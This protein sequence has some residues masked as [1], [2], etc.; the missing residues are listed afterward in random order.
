MND[1]FAAACVIAIVY[2][3]I[4]LIEIRFVSKEAKS[5]R[6]I[7]RDTI[8]VYI[9]SFLAMFIIEHVET[10]DLGKTNAVAFVGAPEF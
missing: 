8:V 7:V 3:T 9:S 2:V 5:V 6:E 10:S 1:K 4:K